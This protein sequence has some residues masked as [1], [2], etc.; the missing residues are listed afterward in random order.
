MDDVNV[1]LIIVVLRNSSIPVIADE[2]VL[3]LL[4]LSKVCQLWKI[5]EKML[6]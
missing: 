6:K 1:P 2:P 4:F 3:K 5:V